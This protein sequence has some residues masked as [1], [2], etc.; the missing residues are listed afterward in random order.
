[1]RYMQGVQLYNMCIPLYEPIRL[2]TVDTLEQHAVQ[3]ISLGSILSYHIF[4]I[5]DR[6]RIIPN[7][8]YLT[9]KAKLILECRYPARRRT[10]YGFCLV[11]Y[12]FI[13][14][15][16]VDHLVLLGKDRAVYGHGCVGAVERVVGRPLAGRGGQPDVGQVLLW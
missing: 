13:G 9:D 12:N 8:K 5:S 2:E 6:G 14:W 1:M 7:G 16:I 15:A 4:W 11:N 3:N 10:E